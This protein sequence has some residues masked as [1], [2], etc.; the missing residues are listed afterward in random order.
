MGPV[1]LPLSR[2]LL[3]SEWG[4]P[5]TGFWLQKQEGGSA[6][7]PETVRP[8]ECQSRLKYLIAAPT[9]CPARTRGPKR[10]QGAPLPCSG[11]SRPAEWK[12][13]AGLSGAQ[14]EAFSRGRSGKQGERG[15]GQHSPELTS[16]A[17][18][19]CGS[20]L[21]FFLPHAP[22]EDPQKP[23]RRQPSW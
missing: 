1:S 13:A 3:G 21:P 2:L 10:N 6:Y 11:V 17:M 12:A 18:S 5:S 9:P 19:M 23:E 20:V 14:A 22:P 7:P 16:A 4:C 8:R 15:G